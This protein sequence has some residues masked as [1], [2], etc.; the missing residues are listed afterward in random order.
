MQKLK[1][2][3]DNAIKAYQGADTKGKKLLEDL[4][5]PEVFVLKP[6]TERVKTWEDACAIKG[7]DP[8]SSLPYPEPANDLQIAIN[9]TF[10]M[11]IICEVLCEDWVADF[12]NSSQYKYTPY[13]TWNNA[14][15][16]FSD[17]DYGDWNTGTYVGSRLVFPTRELAVYAGEQFIDIYNKF[18][19]KP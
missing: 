3:A 11:F 12:N 6:I 1:I 7:I 14:G 4:F 8:V 2:T 10:Q 19:T 17:T 18:L 15:F 9:G 13:F 16:G 5:G